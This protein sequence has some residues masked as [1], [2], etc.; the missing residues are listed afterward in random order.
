MN[1]IT[2]EP[3]PWLFRLF[4]RITFYAATEEQLDATSVEQLIHFTEGTLRLAQYEK[5]LDSNKEDIAAT[6]QRFSHA[7]DNADFLQE[8]S[9]PYEEAGQKRNTLDISPGD[10]TVTAPMPG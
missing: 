1:L 9:R 7:R 8:Q 5:W 6:I 4:G 3:R 10:E 2:T